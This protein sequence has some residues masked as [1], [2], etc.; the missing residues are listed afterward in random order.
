MGPDPDH[1]AVVDTSGRIHGTDRLSIADASIVPS[2]PAAFTHILAVMIT[3]RL[4]EQIASARHSA[5]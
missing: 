4:S 5:I 3:E 2:G 1:D